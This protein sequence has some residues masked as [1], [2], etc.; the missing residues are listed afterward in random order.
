[1]KLLFEEN[2]Q[3]L[4]YNNPLEHVLNCNTIYG[5]KRINEAQYNTATLRESQLLMQHLC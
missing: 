1:M 3:I 5:L 4:S 2:L